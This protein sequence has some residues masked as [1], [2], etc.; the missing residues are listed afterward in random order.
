MYPEWFEG[1]N[2]WF[3][4]NDYLKLFSYWF[5]CVSEEA[6]GLLCIS[7][8]VRKDVESWFAQHKLKRQTPPSLSY[9]HLG[10]DIN[11]SVPTTGLPADAQDIIEHLGA[12]TSFLMVGTLEPRKGHELALNAIEG[13]WAQGKD[14]NLVFVGRAGWKITH[15]IERIKSHPRFGTNLFWLDGISDEYLQKVYSNCS[16]LLAL[17]V[18][19]GFGLPLIEAAYFHLPRIVREIPVFREVC[20]TEATYFTG[21]SSAEL[22][23]LLE[24]WIQSYTGNETTYSNKIQTWEESAMQLITAIGKMRGNERFWRTNS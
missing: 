12:T 21:T 18:A 8:A 1:T 3:E 14:V 11:L 16:A 23:A 15:L 5:D 22:L 7:E 6:D 20:G 2:D 4:G 9:F 19:E 17:S 13:L 24:D 10:S